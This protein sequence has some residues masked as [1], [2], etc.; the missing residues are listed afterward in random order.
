M[1]RLLR[2]L[3]EQFSRAERH[4]DTVV[5]QLEGQSEGQSDPCERQERLQA[6]AEI[7]A[8]MLGLHQALK[9]NYE[10]DR[11]EF[12][13]ELVEVQVQREIAGEIVVL[14]VEGFEEVSTG[15]YTKTG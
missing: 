3:R 11:G 15:V 5:Q 7:T 9:L 6:I 13:G 14:D 8:E 2:L 10:P 4:R 12:G 1:P